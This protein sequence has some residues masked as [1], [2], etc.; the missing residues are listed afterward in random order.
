M[1]DVQG[2]PNFGASWEGFALEQII[3]ALETRDTSFWATHAD[4]DKVNEE[5]VRSINDGG[6]LYLTKTKT[7]G[8]TVI[9][10]V[11]GQTYTTWKHVEEGWHAVGETASGILPTDLL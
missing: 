1:A 4:V 2:H 7:H 9:R 10:F 11:I 3:A 5:L 6:R 8:R